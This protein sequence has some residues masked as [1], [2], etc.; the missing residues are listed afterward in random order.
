MGWF[1]TVLSLPWESQGQRGHP[2]GDKHP[3]PLQ[4]H[5]PRRLKPASSSPLPHAAATDC[6]AA[7]SR[8]PVPPPAARKLTRRQLN[9]PP[10][11]WW[12]ITTSRK[13]PWLRESRLPHL[14]MQGTHV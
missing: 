11:C 8:T 12:P 9:G 1:T 10:A 3:P 2:R 5:L 13:R 4:F 6:A 14:A 7:A